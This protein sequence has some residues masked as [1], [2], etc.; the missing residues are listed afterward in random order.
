M[1]ASHYDSFTTVYDVTQ[2]PDAPTAY[3]GGNMTT[4]V[5]FSTDTQVLALLREGSTVTVAGSGATGGSAYC[6]P[7]VVA[8]VS[9]LVSKHIHDDMVNGNQL[10]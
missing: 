10:Q 3:F 8:S 9:N 6:P 1:Q 4:R 7:T 2:P 5:Y